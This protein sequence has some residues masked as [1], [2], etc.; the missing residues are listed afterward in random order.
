MKPIAIL[1]A[2][3]FVG[4][5]LVEML[6][7]GQRRPL[8][9]IVA[10]PASLAPLARFSLDCRL[11]DPT[12]PAKL[13]AALEDCDVLINLATGNPEVI[14]AL[15]APVYAAA[16]RARVRRLVFTSSAAVH[17]Q[18]PAP[19]TTEAT[20]LPAR[21]QFPYNTAKAQAEQSLRRARAAGPVELVILR[22][23]I[24]WGPRSRWVVDAVWGI[25]SGTFGWLDG[26]RGIIN[27]IYVDNLV[28]A[29]DLA[30]HAPVDKETFLL[31]DPAPANWR[32]FYTPWLTACGVAPDSVPD[33]PPFSPRHG[34][35]AQFERLRVHP[36]TQRLAPSV[37]GVLKRTLKAMAAAVPEPPAPD[38]FG[39]YGEIATGPTPLSEE[40]TALQRCAWRFPVTAA[41]SRLG[42]N[43]LVDWPTAVERT[44]AW[45]RFADLLPSSVAGD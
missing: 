13:A 39:G 3:G 8:R 16:A 34:W 5:R 23:G 45:L 19:G 43:P 29:L 22:P 42:W 6:H 12:D 37:P 9:P 38:P 44:S 11:A 33:A 20:P 10:R 41:A 28:H 2:S 40:M 21:H 7:L 14:H 35:R 18:A 31:N 30:C 25:R 36:F 15:A 27:P 24:V 1:G 4:V 17:G 32:E 26:G